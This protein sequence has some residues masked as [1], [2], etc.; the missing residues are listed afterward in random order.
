MDTPF[1]TSC[2]FCGLTDEQ[3]K[4]NQHLVVDHPMNKFGSNWPSGFRDD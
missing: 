3:T 2:F 1:L 4:K